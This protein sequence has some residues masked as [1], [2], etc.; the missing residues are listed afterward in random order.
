[1]RA[2]GGRGRGG[3]GML[4]VGGDGTPAARAVSFKPAPP[5]L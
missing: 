4:S 5:P 2:A 1:M 3:K